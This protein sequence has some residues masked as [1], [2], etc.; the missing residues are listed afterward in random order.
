V[1]ERLQRL[2]NALPGDDAAGASIGLLSTLVGA[3]LL[4]RC[5]AD[6]ALSDRI[7]DGAQRW[8]EPRFSS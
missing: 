5:V 4:S 2:A 6:P 8:L 7:L 1:R 3:L